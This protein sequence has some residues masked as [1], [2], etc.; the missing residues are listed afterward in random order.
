MEWIQVIEK[1]NFSMN[2]LYFDNLA[3]ILIN[4]HGFMIICN[5]VKSSEA[6]TSLYLYSISYLC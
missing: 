6:L 5:P 2:K 3:V 4:L 1:S